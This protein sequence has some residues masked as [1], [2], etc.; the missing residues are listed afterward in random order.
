MP[1]IPTNPDEFFSVWLPQSLSPLASKLPSPSSPGAVVFHVGARP[2]LAVRLQ[3]SALETAP[4]LPDDAIVQVSLSEDDFE[5]ILV[6]GAERMTERATD[7]AQTLAVLRALTLDR[8]RVA[9]IRDVAG[10]VAF[11]LAVD[12]GEHRVVLTPGIAAR[13]VTA[14][15]CIVRCALEDFL[16]LQRGDANPFELMMNGKIQISG[17]AQ[18]PMALSSLLV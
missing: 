4:G 2:P 8:E 9:L 17:D 12:G 14:P 18:I 7:P 10:S 1:A 3:N 11:V 5:P 16:A 6:R 15:E 13:N